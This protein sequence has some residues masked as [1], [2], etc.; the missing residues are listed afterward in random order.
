MAEHDVFVE[1]EPTDSQKGSLEYW[2]R[3][4]Q[5]FRDMV[6]PPYYPF[7]EALEMVEQLKGENSE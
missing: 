1:C 7:R 4:V 2:E 5:E 3:K 6:V